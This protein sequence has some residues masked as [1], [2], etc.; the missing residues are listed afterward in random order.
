MS[1]TITF[2]GKTYNSLEEMPARER[3]AY[4]AVMNAF[5]DKDQDGV[6]DLFEGSASMQASQANIVYN[7]QVYHS[8][9]ELPPEARLRYQQAMG[10]LDADRDGIPDFVEGLL[11]MQP[12][13]TP[14][15]V[16]AGRE[17]SFSSP[18]TLPLNN[19]PTIEPEGVNWRTLLLSALL[20][21]LLCLGAVTL[22]VLFA[23]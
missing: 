18:A 17:P 1:A 22:W 7:G 9:D 12:A 19:T 15:P 5:A 20:I 3:A 14:G 4:E 2:N 16:A 21:G 6:P 8:L 23:Q 10:K 11:G 13:S